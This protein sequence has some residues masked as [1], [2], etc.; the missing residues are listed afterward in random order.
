[1]FWA[2]EDLIGLG[3][4]PLLAPNRTHEA[5]RIDLVGSG[6]RRACGKGD[7]VV[8][9]TVGNAAITFKG[10]SK[11]Y[12]S[13]GINLPKLKIDHHCICY[14]INHK[15]DLS[16]KIVSFELSFAYSTR[17]IIVELIASPT[18]VPILKRESDS[19]PEHLDKLQNCICHHECV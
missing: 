13:S 15:M 2:N 10:R 7:L 5:L 8:L 19:P 1:M 17:R 18:S 11:L 3:E 6:D 9:V 14:C 4:R 16:M 12:Y